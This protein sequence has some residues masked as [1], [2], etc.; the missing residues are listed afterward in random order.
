MD[1][2]Q[3]IYPSS[4]KKSNKDDASEAAGISE[5]GMVGVADHGPDAIVSNARKSDNLSSTATAAV[6]FH[7]YCRGCR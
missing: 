5:A 2:V 4:R 1:T 3:E 6:F 7:R